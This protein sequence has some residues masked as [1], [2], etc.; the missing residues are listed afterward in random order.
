[1]ID[2][3]LRKCKSTGLFLGDKPLSVN[4]TDLFGDSPLHLVSGWG[5][6]EAVEA[7]LAAGA[8]VDA[9]GDKGQTPLFQATSIEVVKLLVAAGA[10]ATIVDEFG[11]TAETFLRSV[12]QIEVADYIRANA[13]RS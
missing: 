9:V 7:L 8:E 3:I 6:S 10:D 1:M 11:E 12:G 4:D 2:D 13:K 5:D